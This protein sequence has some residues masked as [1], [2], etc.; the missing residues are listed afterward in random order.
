MLF[1]FLPPNLFHLH[2]SI[3]YDC[4][5]GTF[6][7]LH[8]SY[9]IR[10]PSPNRT[11]YE[12]IFLQVKSGSFPLPQPNCSYPLKCHLF[13]CNSNWTVQKLQSTFCQ[14]CKKKKCFLFSI[15]RALRFPTFLAVIELYDVTF[16][17]S[18]DSM[19]RTKF[20]W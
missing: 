18:C 2:I 12:Q 7:T 16:R 11:F 4:I 10:I 13:N 9:N 6:Q 5:E 15:F 19:N 1:Q 14:L 20:C 3:T 17:R 8:V